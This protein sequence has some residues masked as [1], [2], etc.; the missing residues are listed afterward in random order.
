MTR[1]GEWEERHYRVAIKNNKVQVHIASLHLCKNE[2][3]SGSMDHD[4][5]VTCTSTFRRRHKGKVTYSPTS[6]FMIF[7]VCSP[8][9][10]VVVPTKRIIRFQE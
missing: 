7:S 6:L 3:A 2:Q 8:R 1:E 4:M 9:R 10:N 5:S